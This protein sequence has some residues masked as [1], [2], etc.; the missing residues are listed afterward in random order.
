MPLIDSTVLENGNS[1]EINVDYSQDTDV[2]F[3]YPKTDVEEEIALWKIKGK[4]P[5]IRLIWNEC[6][7]DKSNI[8]EFLYSNNLICYKKTYRR[9]LSFTNALE[10]NIVIVIN[11]Y[12]NKIRKSSFLLR[13]KNDTV[14]DLTHFSF[15]E[16]EGENVKKLIYDY[17]E[18]I[19][20]FCQNDVGKD[21]LPDPYR[22][23]M[24]DIIEKGVLY[25]VNDPN[26]L[27]QHIEEIFKCYTS[28][29]SAYKH[30]LETNEGIGVSTVKLTPV[31]YKLNEMADFM[32]YFERK[33]VSQKFKN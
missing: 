31:F 30:S 10:Y 12:S 25:Y 22:G 2:D 17:V 24:K 29:M 26:E 7:I 8:I 28:E 5:E 15:Y 6:Y 4:N 1:V 9:F 33:I 16:F 18:N 13:P 32:D 23:R 3:H 27:I 21:L 19:L 14:V 11:D 20:E